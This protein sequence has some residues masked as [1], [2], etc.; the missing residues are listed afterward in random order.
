MI[1][2]LRRQFILVTMLSTLAVLTV[3]IGA[4]NIANYISMTSSADNL[5]A[6]IVDNG[7]TFPEFFMGRRVDFGERKRPD[8]EDNPDFTE[9]KPPSKE[10]RKD[11]GKRQNRSFSN[12]TPYMTRF[13]SVEYDPLEEE[14]YTAYTGQI[15]SISEQ[16]AMLY[17][18]TVIKKFQKYAKMKGFYGNYRYVVRPDENGG[19][20]VVFLDV[21]KEKQSF[22]SVLLYS[23]ILSGIGLFAVFILVWFFS[24]KVFK[25]VEESDRKQKRFITDASHELK[26]PLTIISAN[27]EVLEMESEESQWTESIKKQVG[28]M[29]TLVEQMVDLSRLDENAELVT[30]KFSLSDAV[31]DTAGVYL[32]VAEK[33]GDELIID[34]EENISFNGDEKKI[35]QMTGLLLDNAVKYASVSKSSANGNAPA[36]DGKPWIKISLKQK[37]KKIIFK[38]MNSVENMKSGNH[39]ELFERFYRPDDSRNS[40]KGGSGIGLSIVKSIVEAH[41]GKIN[42]YSTDGESIVFEAFFV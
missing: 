20:L 39:N 8:F 19:R 42:A 26:T 34:V 3:I 31:L 24:K 25:P 4:L 40:K 33:H 35:R 2:K 11:D 12:E 7:G 13:F 36:A 29:N 28:R 23:L 10:E 41:R 15:A 14:Q 5:L 6:I 16:D 37:G 9:P 22:Q 17:A 32:P 30:E 18:E 21:S 27:V 1:Q 38:C